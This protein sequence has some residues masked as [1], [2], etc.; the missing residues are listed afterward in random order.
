MVL[1]QM[2]FKKNLKLL[3]R[4]RIFDLMEQIPSHPLSMIIAPMGYGKTASLRSYIERTELE[5]LWM[6][7]PRATNLS[8][9]ELFWFLLVRAVTRRDAA[10]AQRLSRMGFPQNSIDVFRIIDMLHDLPPE[11]PLLVVIDDLHFIESAAVYEFIYQVGCSGI[12][13][14][15]IVILSRTYPNF[16]TAEMELKGT[17]FV[18]GPQ[19]LAFTA[20]EAD[21]YYALVQFDPPAEVRRHIFR[22]SQGW[23][24][25]ILLLVEGYQ[26]T[27]R[28][29]DNASINDMFVSSV[30]R[31]YSEYEKRLLT[32]VAVL[33][34]FTQKMLN[35]VLD[36]PNASTAV[37]SACKANAFIFRDQQGRYC[38]HQ[39][40]RDFLLSGQA[41]PL[42]DSSVFLH[43]AAQWYSDNGN[44]KEA[45]R[46][47]MIAN[48][49]D[50][51]M[52]TL[53]IIP[54]M[55]V[56]TLN[57]DTMNSFFIEG[58]EEQRFRYPYAFLKN[59]FY[60]LI[61]YN[62]PHLVRYLDEF[63]SYF[64]THSHPRYA[65]TLLL[66]ESAVLRSSM[67]FN[68]LDS[69]LAQI[70]CAEALMP[71]V[72]SQFRTKKSS[73]SHTSPHMTYGYYKEAGSFRRIADIFA[74]DFQVHVRVTGGC[75]AGCPLLAQAE[76]ALETMDLPRV[77]ALAFQA[78]NEARPYQQN[79]VIIGAY[80][81]LARLY[82]LQ[83]RRD[84][85]A[86]FQERVR[87]IKKDET[88]TSTLYE[89]DNC[90]GYISCLEG[91]LEDVPRW[92]SQADIPQGRSTFKRLSFNL[93]VSGKAL[94]LAGDYE[95]LER[96]T[97]Q[98][99]HY[100]NQFSYRLGYL[101][102]WMYRAI[103]KYHLYGLSVGL[104]ELKRAVELAVPDHI[105]A[106][107]V[108]CLPALLPMLEAYSGGQQEMALIRELL[109]FAGRGEPSTEGDGLLLTRR[110]IEVMEYLSEG[111]SQV[112]VGQKLFI[113]QNTVKRHL[114]N[115][116][117]K[118]D[119]SNKTQAINRYKRL[120]QKGNTP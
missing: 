33:D 74:R 40:F 8:E 86:E 83:G 49:R 72:T 87:M 111:Y 68:D 103:A 57:L 104:S 44:L 22:I 15:R 47:W 90:L 35:Y 12:P 79:W 82:L 16:P 107:F 96:K 52:E 58:D 88:N 80:L 120:F 98:F 1:S 85:M 20:E 97:Y 109:S 53:E 37:E 48:D 100:F 23:I 101:H 43:R 95:K 73:F 59:I 4:K 76:Y 105:L 108:E 84:R 75:G 61:I 24:A 94:L 116:Y 118:L 31:Y 11:R 34:T 81:T 9:T 30:F 41:A 114:Q 102:N 55:E 27:G 38:F 36:D 77:E 63:D 14:L 51:I 67:V 29:D 3:P 45:I 69:M 71:G 70:R 62:S 6:T 18:I 17:L 13:W 32:Q 93:I 106:P 117:H 2:D 39:M 10:F 119:A 46:Y 65:S 26:N 28:L 7:M 56:L 66:G 19:D 113:A 110:E 115:I 64:S 92:I 50:R 78:I 99:D 89:I 21:E 5:S 54:P 60:Q 42:Q 112:E 25:S 91:R